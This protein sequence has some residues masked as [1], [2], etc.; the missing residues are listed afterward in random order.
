MGYFQ[1]EQS[2]TETSHSGLAWQSMTILPGER[3]SAVLS[4]VM[5]FPMLS[6]SAAS[7]ITPLSPGH[8]DFDAVEDIGQNPLFSELTERGIDKSG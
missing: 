4:N 1:I 6:S 2:A 3:P 8:G 7:R 5:A